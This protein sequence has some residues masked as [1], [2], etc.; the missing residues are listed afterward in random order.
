MEA[1]IV[2]VDLTLFQTARFGIMGRLTLC[3]GKLG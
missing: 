3:G 1:N 2:L